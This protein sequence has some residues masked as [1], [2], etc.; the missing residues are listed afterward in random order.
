[1]IKE[2]VIAD[3]YRLRRSLGKGTFGE[4]FEALDSKFQPPRVVAVK[5]LHPQFFADSQ[6]RDSIR[7]EASSLARFNHPHILRVYD[8]E[9]TGELAYI[10]TDFATGGSLMDKLR[11]DMTLPAHKLSIEE[12]TKILE[13]IAGALDEAHA[14]GLIH[15]DIKPQNI[16]LD[17]RGNYLLADFGLATAI[18]STA[19][20]TMIH[21]PVTGTPLY[22]AP[23]Q[24]EGD[25]A[26]AS[27][28]YALGV[29]TFQMLAGE[30]PFKGNSMALAYQHIEGA[31]PKLSDRTAHVRYP[32]A[33]DQ[34]LALAMAKKP[35]NR[36][37]T[38]GEFFQRFK[39]ALESPLPS[40]NIEDLL[41]EFPAPVIEPAIKALEPAGITHQTEPVNQVAHPH[42][43]ILSDHTGCVNAVAWSRD[44]SLL[45]SA[46][47]DRTVRLWRANGALYATL[48]PHYGD[49][50][51][52][53]W[54]KD[55]KMLV[56][57]SENG[58][59]QLWGVYGS[60]PPL[61]TQPP[62][63]G[64]VYSTLLANLAGHKMR[65]SALEWSPNGQRFAVASFDKTVTLWRNDGKPLATLTGH[66][67][68]VNT[69]AWSPDG[70]LLATAS[71]DKTIRL[72]TEAG[73][74]L[75]VFSRHNAAVWGLAWSPQGHL[76]ATV[77]MDTKTQ[78]CLWHADGRLYNICNGHS[79]AVSAV[80]WSPQGQLFATAS[81]DKTAIIWRMNGALQTT[82]LGHTG[83]VTALA[84]SPNGML[85]AT[86]SNDET[87]RIWGE[88]GSLK[89]ILAGHKE[90]I[91]SLA[92]SPD[93]QMLATA[94]ADCKV[95]LWQVNFS[96][97]PQ[98]SW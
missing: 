7:K 92:W 24:W 12:V 67:M 96:V 76:L 70:Q 27:D 61:P 87:V 16:L 23:E 85:L 88:D 47:F 74:L 63:V 62:P 44:G 56:S 33:L 84:W 81:W 14:D 73:K 68:P 60:Y 98:W 37:K 42:P 26:K 77:S 11:P 32:P 79:A 94:A 20:S 64:G 34:V 6:V 58:A 9:I 19:T 28:I 45:A 46:S 13:Q 86:A 17:K 1:M 65:V 55:G 2:R 69:L 15:R 75:S 80:A 18:S 93:S 5:V 72:W 38:A 21:T 53:A 89:A 52:I 66:T 82:L 30:T 8:Y 40:V 4:V 97:T 83:S 41:K 54:S 78:V 90:A 3:R 35:L 95:C 29:L 91:T 57:G 31:I 25:T 43:T 36:P 51:C 39:K 48:Q 50:R 71:N 59:V 22:M 49:V 10:V